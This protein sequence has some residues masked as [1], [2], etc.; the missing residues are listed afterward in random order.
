MPY[1]VLGYFDNPLTNKAR[2]LAQF[3]YKDDLPTKEQAQ[4]IAENWRKSERYPFIF[5]RNTQTRETEKY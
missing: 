4:A 3:T 1:Q 2:E 5:I